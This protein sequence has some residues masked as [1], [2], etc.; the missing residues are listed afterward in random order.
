[1]GCIM[2]RQRHSFFASFPLTSVISDL[3]TLLIVGYCM[4]HLPHHHPPVP[5]FHSDIVTLLFPLTLVLSLN[6]FFLLSVSLVKTKIKL[7]NFL[8]RC[9][10]ITHYKTEI[11]IN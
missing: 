4:S 9:P 10:R 3:S 5:F 2:E 1:M 6:V 11:N 7:N 8:P